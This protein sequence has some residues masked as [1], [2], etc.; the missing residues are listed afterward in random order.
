MIR[1][2]L[3]L[4]GL[5]SNRLLLHGNPRLVY[6]VQL[7]RNSGRFLLGL[8]VEPSFVLPQT[9]PET[10]TAGIAA[11]WSRRWLEKR[12]DN[13]AVLARAERH[14]LSHP[15][16]HGACIGVLEARIE[17]VTIFEQ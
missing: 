4:V 14:T 8:D 12:I 3:D 2:A 7:A 15:I 5:P 17:Q 6:G 10:A 9:A 13:A 1:E 11:F 16:S